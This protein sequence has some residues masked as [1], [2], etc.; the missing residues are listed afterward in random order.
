HGVARARTAAARA[1][2]SRPRA[3][4]TK[5]TGTTTW[6]SS[7]PVSQATAKRLPPRVQRRVAAHYAHVAERL[8]EHLGVQRADA[9]S[10]PPGSELTRQHNMHAEHVFDAVVR[11]TT[12]GQ[13][14]GAHGGLPCPISRPAPRRAVARWQV[15]AAPSVVGG[16]DVCPRGVLV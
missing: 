6:S 11:R 7:V 5:P 16:G 1:P 10:R 9:A 12:G 3:S 8:A 13:N 14:L 15:V 4:Q 2:A